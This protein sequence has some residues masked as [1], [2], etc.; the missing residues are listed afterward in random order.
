MRSQLFLVRPRLTI[1]ATI[2]GI[3]LAP[4]GVKGQI[5]AGQV[6][7]LH[8]FGAADGGNP[9]TGL[10]QMSNGLFAG[11][12]KGQGPLYGQPPTIYT[13]TPGGVVTMLYTFAADSSQGWQPKGLIQASDGNL[14]G[15]AN[16][17]SDGTVSTLFRVTPQGA[18]TVLHTF[19]PADHIGTPTGGL[20]E[21]RDGS[22]YGL[23]NNA[24]YIGTVYQ[25]DPLTQLTS[26]FHS[27]VGGSGP[28]GVGFGMLGLGPDGRLYGVSTYYTAPDGTLYYG[29][30]YAIDTS[31]NLT[32]LSINKG[33]ISAGASDRPAFGSDGYLYFTS[34]GGGTSTACVEGCGTIFRVAMS[35]SDPELLYSFTGG[36]DHVGPKGLVA[37][38]DGMFYGSYGSPPESGAAS[39]FQFNPATRSL[40]V[41]DFPQSAGIWPRNYL[42]QSPRGVI[43]G[44]SQAGRGG[45]GTAYVLNVAAP[46]PRPAIYDFA[47]K[48]GP[49][50]TEV[51]VWGANFV[52]V[53]SVTLNG[54]AAGRG[55]RSTGVL[56]FVVPTGAT[57][58]AITVTTAAGG[59]A[60]SSASFTV[61]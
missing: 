38:S 43:M 48:S 22:L 29:C 21:A 31:G 53:N 6:I 46:P 10:I 41:F 35:G 17:G 12:T 25:Y 56:S 60:T 4:L 50:G 57:T 30:N 52:W 27:F 42:V 61:Q 11:T 23:A 13:M 14:Y 28:W 8:Q 47:P 45:P 39:I 16:Q 24:G 55:A 15:A 54:M 18:F 36:F 26:L 3:G 19:S 7:R 5:P 33:S 51:T 40:A 49:P 2:L 1:L 34:S 59:Q 20:V 9:A 32:V 58:G 37:G 44:T